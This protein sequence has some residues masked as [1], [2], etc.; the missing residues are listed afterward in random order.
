MMWLKAC[1][2]CRGDIYLE[3]DI[4]ESYMK[5]LQ[6]GHVLRELERLRATLPAASARP[7]TSAA[8]EPAPGRRAA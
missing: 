1:P 5:C 2:R 4:F 3:K 7:A 8:T 6:C